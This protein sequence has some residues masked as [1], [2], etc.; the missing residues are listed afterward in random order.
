M[1]VAG[2][3]SRTVLLGILFVVVVLLLLPLL[4]LIIA[5]TTAA[6]AGWYKHSEV[7][8][9]VY[10]YTWLP[11]NEAPNEWMARFKG[12][13][14]IVSE[15]PNIS[16]E[17]WTCYNTPSGYKTLLDMYTVTKTTRHGYKDTTTRHCKIHVYNCAC[18]WPNY[19]I[20]PTQISLK[21]GDFP[22][23]TFIW[24]EVAWGRHN[25]T[26]F[27]YLCYRWSNSNC[28]FFTNLQFPEIR[29]KHVEFNHPFGM[30]FCE[31]T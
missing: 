4:P 25:L 2:H 16:P 6:A 22:Y 27:I 5:T 26:R 9:S 20:S 7:K 11:Q 28:S 1:S 21:E 3:K 15:I 14:E 19:N 23:E 17:I 30:R 10:T 24:G 8:Y 18:I 31:V 29:K 12:N 13:S